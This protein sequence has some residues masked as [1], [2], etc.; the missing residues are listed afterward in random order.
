MR[1]VFLSLPTGLLLC[2]VMFLS[3]PEAASELPT[4]HK[5]SDERPPIPLRKT[6]PPRHSV[7]VAQGSPARRPKKPERF[8]AIALLEQSLQRYQKSVRGY[9]C[10]FEKQERIGGRLQP[11]ETIQVAFREKPF[12]VYFQ[13]LRGA[14]RAERAQ[15]VEGDNNGKM[16]A[17]PSGILARRIAGNV[18]VRD[19]DGPD[20]RQAG[21]YPL[22]GFGL[23]K[24]TERT[25]AAWK[26]ERAR[27]ALHVK[28]LGVYTVK[29]LDGRP[30]YKLHCTYD[31][32][33]DDG[34]T[35]LTVYLDRE[36]LL[37]TGSVLEGKDARGQPMR[38]AT[39]YFRNIHFNPRFKESQFKRSALIP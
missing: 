31:R 21:R 34:I 35:D 32:P 25:L 18:V 4:E 7:L 5:V 14:R 27:G 24:G 22:T 8:D 26:M 12:S 19:V 10:I 15:Y 6:A 11:P 23:R 37:Q 20:A 2:L 33:L 1:W 3:R 29:E 28:Y 30:C 13:W 36:T 16:L 39:Y 38:I 9:T 17:R